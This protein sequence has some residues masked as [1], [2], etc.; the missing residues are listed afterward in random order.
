MEVLL[1]QIDIPEHLISDN[2]YSG[3]AYRD[4]KGRIVGRYSGYYKYEFCLTNN[5]L[6]DDTFTF[7]RTRINYSVHSDELNHIGDF[8]V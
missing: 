5:L 3:E 7:D 1:Y 2:Y 4:S 8:N 6:F